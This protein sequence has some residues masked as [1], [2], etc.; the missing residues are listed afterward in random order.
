M[1]DALMKYVAK[2]KKFTPAIISGISL[3]FFVILIIK[4]TEFDSGLKEK[5]VRENLMEHLIY[6]RSQLEKAL[7]SRIYYTKGVAAYVSIN[8]GISAN[9]FETLARELIREDTVISTMSLSKG[10]IIGAI[11]PKEGHEKAIGLNLLAHPNRKKIVQST[12]NTS[13]TFVAGPV[14]LV[15][16][17]VAFISYTPIFN[18]VSREPGNFWGVTD[19]VILRDKLF[20]EV[21]LYPDDGYYHYALKGIDGTGRTGSCFWGDSAVFNS[22]PVEIDI[23]LPT[24][25]WRLAAIPA[26]GWVKYVDKAA[27]LTYFL[28]ICAV[29][30]SILIWLLAKAW[31]T[32]RANEK[33]MKAL[34]GSM[35]DLIIEY[36]CDGRYNKIAPTNDKLLVMPA[37]KLLGKTLHEVFEPGQA[38]FFLKAIRECLA[39]RQ[40][41]VIDYS[42]DINSKPTWFQA[43]ISYL[44]ERSVIFTAHDNTLKKLAE[45]RLIESEAKLKEL[46]ATKDKFFSLIAHDLKSPLGSLRTISELLSD[47]YNEF[48]EE[49]RI[50]FLALIKESS[51]TV[52]SLLENLLEWSRSQRGVLPF[53]PTEADIHAIVNDTISTVAVA[54]ERKGVKIENNLQPGTS[55]KVDVNMLKTILRNL[56]SNSIKFSMAGGRV[57]IFS[58]IIGG[59]MQIK[60]KDTGIGMAEETLDRLF[61]IEENVSTP[62]TSSETGTGLGLILCREFAEKHGGRIHA[63]SEPGKGSTFIISLPA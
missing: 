26:Y 47:S 49:E 5:N 19:I 52:Y 39:T 14:E 22:D 46:N 16:G 13:K 57:S 23:S 63:E 6:K 61:K 4:Y 58:E 54:A 32:I 31:M 43:R 35:Q 42:I 28:Y 37:S 10:C 45:N 21:E 59:F 1:K 15:E 12:I 11:F 9:T 48:T 38:D 25:T 3:C 40:L 36:D 2:I 33:E 56:L 24:G 29:I 44:S 27:A 7:Y 18:L 34:F 51:R 17:G 50:D 55:L 20:N 41:V 30:I 53:N 62:G 60:V 8:P